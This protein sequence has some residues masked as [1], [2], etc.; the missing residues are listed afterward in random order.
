MSSP[1]PSCESCGM[2]LADAGDVCP[3]CEQGLESDAR[4]TRPTRH[5]CPICMQ[6]FD[7]P[8]RERWPRHAKWYVPSQIKPTC[9]HCHGALR[10]RKNPQL[11]PMLIVGFMIATVVS[12]V[13]LPPEHHQTSLWI[14]L[15][16]YALAHLR[17]WERHVSPRARY[18]K[19]DA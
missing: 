4:W 5:L 16:A 15:V 12:Y 18:A 13:A 3:A 2:P 10:D 11:S 7:H 1:K 8:L 19:D 9:P 17:R 14:L 6:G